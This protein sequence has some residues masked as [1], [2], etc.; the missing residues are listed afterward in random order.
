[1][2]ILGGR[3]LRLNKESPIEGISTWAP[4]SPAWQPLTS[5]GRP[6]EFGWAAGVSTLS[7]GE[8]PH[9]AAFLSQLRPQR[10][11]MN[12]QR[13]SDMMHEGT[14]VIDT[15]FNDLSGHAA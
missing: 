1:M 4:R 15:S 9:L 6:W 7:L 3:C 8:R 11:G 13:A 12:W 14:S 5:R 10:P 2:E